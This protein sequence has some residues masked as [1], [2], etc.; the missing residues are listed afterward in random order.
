[1]LSKGAFV[2]ALAVLAA[3][4]TAQG[5][6][7]ELFCATAS[8]LGLA[9]ES[10]ALMFSVFEKGSWRPAA[11]YI[12]PENV[13][14]ILVPL[15]T[16]SDTDLTKAAVPGRLTPPL[17]KN[18]TVVCFEAA[19]GRPA[20]PPPAPG[21]LIAV[22]RKGEKYHVFVARASDV[23]NPANFTI[24]LPGRPAGQRPDKVEIGRPAAGR[25]AG[26]E[27]Q[28]EATVQQTQTLSYWAAFK[29]HKLTSTSLAPGACLSTEFD[30][31]EGTQQAAVVLTGG[32]T[33]G[34]YQYTIINAFNPS[35]RWSDTVTVLPGS[36]QTVVKWLPPGRAQYS[37][38]I[39]NRNS[40]TAAVY[41]SA[42]VYV[43]NQQYFRNDVIR[44][45][46]LYI[47]TALPQYCNT[48]GICP[49][50][51]HVIQN[52]YFV[53]PG[54]YVDSASQIFVDIYIKV[55]RQSATLDTVYVKWGDVPIGS[56]TGYNSGDFRIFHGTIT[57]PTSLLVFL[58]PTYGLGGSIVIG[59]FT[60]YANSPYEV[61]VKMAVRKPQ[62]LAPAGDATVY[63]TWIRRFRESL[64]VLDKRAFIADL[65]FVKAS[66]TG[67]FVISTRPIIDI[68]TSPWAK[69]TYVSF[70][71]RFYDGSMNPI[72]VAGGAAS[73]VS[74]TS[75]W[76]SVLRQIGIASV[77]LQLYELIK[78]TIDALKGVATGFPVIGYVTFAMDALV[79]AAEASV[80]VER[81]DLYTLKITLWTG[82]YDRVPLVARIYLAEARVPQYV[83]VTRV[84]YWTG[85]LE[86]WV[87]VYWVDRPVLP[88]TSYADVS[89]AGGVTYFPYRTLTCGVQE[90]QGYPIDRCDRA[91]YR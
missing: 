61:E 81:V 23:D 20:A 70:Y 25:G 60:I 12:E 40:G 77:V 6:P 9:G 18:E 33:P 57:V 46:R 89:G 56:L 4:I 37:V 71:V 21:V 55:P 86:P 38:T 16:R 52:S 14:F 91:Y 30:V 51:T 64:L 49:V 17:L 5:P 76:G 42:L 79:N 83:A 63:N 3:V 11:A 75:W 28:P 10:S 87:T 59:P 34:T 24:P 36:L 69:Y 68:D 45:P 85:P 67:H 53:I 72:A 43:T 8:E 15:L 22:E 7:R 74:T 35:N 58:L 65:D 44:T 19:P 50:N 29:L 88:Y 90:S 32:T 62:E 31:P 13:T 26:R 84:E 48:Y 73:S 82:G 39:C 2:L 47:Y 80:S 41:A 54:F 66:G 78:G 1:M 27:S